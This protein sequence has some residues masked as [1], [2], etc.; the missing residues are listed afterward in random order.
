LK[1]ASP[2]V[3]GPFMESRALELANFIQHVVTSKAAVAPRDGHG[4]ISVLG[5]SLGNLYCLD[6]FSRLHTLPDDLQLTLKEYVRSLV[7]FGSS[8]HFLRGCNL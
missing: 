2:D 6:W 1:T 5:W 3:A 8:F 7:I 4:G